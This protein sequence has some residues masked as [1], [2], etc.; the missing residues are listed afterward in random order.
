MNYRLQQFKEAM[1]MRS[2]FAVGRFSMAM[3]VLL[4]TVMLTTA[5]FAQSKQ[6][7]GAATPQAQQVFRM[8]IAHL[9]PG[10][11]P[12]WANFLKND[13]VPLM[14][15]GGVS[16]LGVMRTNVF[17]DAGT[18]Y[19][20]SPIA[21]LSELDGQNPIAKS[22]SPDGL[23]VLMA[24]VQRCVSSMRTF[25]LTARPDLGIPAKQGYEPKMGVL[26]TQSVTPGRTEEY[27]KSL[28]QLV[29]VLGKTNAK[30]V[31]TGKVGLGG[32]PNQYL[33]FV[34]FDSFADL[35]KFSP[36]FQK[37]AAE[38]KLAS[39]AGIVQH[40]EWTTVIT[41]PE[42]GIQAPARKN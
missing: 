30:A 16:W 22:I 35:E 15:K 39:Q 27:E 4:L 17:G 5:G 33:I 32:N 24:N 21:S 23:A 36:A 2:Y 18:Y 19:M 37:A 26:A 25:A 40:V 38:A 34:A 20:M 3:I 7:A 12:E 28:K 11:G 8:T 31:M 29:A 1:S 42:L 9:K 41:V 14:K 10:M 13:L 6:A